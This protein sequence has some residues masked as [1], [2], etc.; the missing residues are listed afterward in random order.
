MEESSP[1]RDER[2]ETTEQAETQV[3][4]T[5]EEKF[6][7]V[8]STDTKRDELLTS[9]RQL[10]TAGPDEE[11]EFFHAK[12]PKEIHGLLKEWVDELHEGVL[13]GEA[14]LTDFIREHRQL[15][16]RASTALATSYTLNGG[17][18]SKFIRE[19]LADRKE[20]QMR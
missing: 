10:A 6:I 11:A 2:N 16:W 15:F 18:I 1:H 20:K 8:D 17:I 7:E 5:L 14:Q 19:N 3:V 4:C 9:F 12:S 13:L